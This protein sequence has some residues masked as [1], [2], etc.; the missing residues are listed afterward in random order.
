MSSHDMVMLECCS[1][2]MPR[3]CFKLKFENKIRVL[4]HPTLTLY[5]DK[6]NIAFHKSKEIFIRR[7]HP[8]A[9]NK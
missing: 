4:I 9:Q 2:I 1:S 5:A 8:F 7:L 6:T 3:V